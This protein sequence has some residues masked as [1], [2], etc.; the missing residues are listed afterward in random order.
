MKLLQLSLLTLTLMMAIV[1][2]GC[3]EMNLLSEDSGD[4]IEKVRSEDKTL[5]EESGDDGITWGSARDP[6]APS[7]I[8]TVSLIKT[9]ITR[10]KGVETLFHAEMDV[11]TQENIVVVLEICHTDA[12]VEN[13][14]LVMTPGQLTSEKFPLEKDVLRVKILPYE[15]I[16]KLDP[17]M[18]PINTKAGRVD[19]T[20]YPVQERRYKINPKAQRVSK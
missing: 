5:S 8:P 20:K 18:V 9:Q 11:H 15:I 17:Q 3:G 1:I 4:G 14:I 19:L 2:G 6:E 10:P 16:L 7:T 12:S 13:A